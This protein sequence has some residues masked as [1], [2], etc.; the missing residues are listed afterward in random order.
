MSKDEL[1]DNNNQE[2][3][4]KCTFEEM[5][6]CEFIQPTDDCAN[7]YLN[8]ISYECFDKC[9]KDCQ[10][11]KKIIEYPKNSK[12]VYKCGI[13]KCHNVQKKN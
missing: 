3:S 1:N 6:D 10:D 4:L 8:N 11:P 9:H 2:D 5:G 7:C 13:Q 12:F